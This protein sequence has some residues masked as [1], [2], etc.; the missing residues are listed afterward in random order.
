MSSADAL[1][2]S[3][4]YVLSDVSTWK[5]QCGR[6]PPGNGKSLKSGTAATILFSGEVAAYPQIDLEESE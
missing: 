1:E 2:I 3:S 6:P 5:V 4:S